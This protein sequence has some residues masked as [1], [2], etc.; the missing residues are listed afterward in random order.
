MDT[1]LKLALKYQ[2]AAAQKRAAY[3]KYREACNEMVRADEEFD[4]VRLKV[5]APRI[6][7]LKCAE[8]YAV[9]NAAWALT[10]G[11]VI[12]YEWTAEEDVEC[13]KCGE[14]APHGYTSPLYVDPAGNERTYCALCRDRVHG[15][16]T[17]A[18]L[19]EAMDM[20]HEEGDWVP[21]GPLVGK[22]KCSTCA[23]APP[24][25]WQLFC[26][27]LRCEACKK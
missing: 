11:I 25:E 24:I 18:E 7:R 1:E 4:K 22:L 21:L 27:K 12:D 5:F 2:R 19:I 20:E 14:D 9:I 16:K 10:N 15:H 13:D 23:T 17:L 6:K 3:R 8:N 26:T